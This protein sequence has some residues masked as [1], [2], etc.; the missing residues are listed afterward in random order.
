MTTTIA[1][2]DPVD[3]ENKVKEMYYQVATQ[4]E[5][6]FHFEMGRPLAERLGYNPL[7]LD[8]IPAASID[9]FAGV[10]YHTRLADIN[11]GEFVLDLGSGSGMD[12]FVASL[13]AGSAGRVVGIEMTDAQLEKA[14]SLRMIGGFE[15]ISYVNGNLKDLP[16]D[17]QAFDVVISNGVINLCDD[18]SRAFSEA[19]RVLRKGGRLALSDIVSES[20]LPEHIVCNASLWAACIGGA[21]Q[22]DAYRKAVEAAGFRVEAFYDNPQYG[23]ISKSA[24]G[25]TIKYGVKSISLLAV[26][27]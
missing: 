27:L 6:D 9:S 25:A 11:P 16:F 13:Y 20:E 19:A 17:D 24:E 7:D 14:E 4:P 8:R 3:L 1:T 12:T 21:M 2:F 23:F 10:G 26:R 18:K 22:V 15:S 5:S